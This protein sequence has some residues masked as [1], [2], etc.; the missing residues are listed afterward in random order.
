M[1][2]STKLK[3]KRMMKAALPTGKVQTSDPRRANTATGADIAIDA[4]TETRNM[5]LLKTLEQLRAEISHVEV[6]L[7]IACT[8]SDGR[9]IRTR[10]WALTYADMHTWPAL[11]Q[12]HAP[13]SGVAGAEPLQLTPPPSYR[14]RKTS[15]YFGHVFV[16]QEGSRITTPGTRR[17]AS[18]KAM[19]MR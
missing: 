16:T 19:A 7:K 3:L 13:A 14:C 11:L 5:E 8:S 2:K 18:E 10:S 9:K 15:K 12:L 17:P 6:P 4:L 1:T